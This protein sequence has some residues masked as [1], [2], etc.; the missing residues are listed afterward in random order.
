MVTVVDIQPPSI[1]CPANV[2]VKTVNPGDTTVMVSY[3]QPVA[4]DNCGASVVCAPPSGSAFPVGGTTV[5]CT[6][7]D[8]ASNQTSCSFQVSVF[9]FV[10]KNYTT[11]T[12]LRLSSTTGDYEYIEC[13]KGLKMTGTAVV[14]KTSCKISVTDSGSDPKRPDRSVM[15]TI[16]PCTRVASG[17]VRAVSSATTY[18]LNDS[19]ITNNPAGCT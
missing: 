1:S 19:D 12:F 9:D 7:T 2:L 14:T 8:T 13:G 15:I 17:S 16:N 3:A 10:V 11:N 18:P 6:A 5:V 4:S